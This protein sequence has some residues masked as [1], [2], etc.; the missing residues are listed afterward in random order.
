MTTLEVIFLI[1]VII[2]AIVLM[3]FIGLAFYLAKFA[4]DFIKAISRR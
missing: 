4:M 1:I 2:M 3:F